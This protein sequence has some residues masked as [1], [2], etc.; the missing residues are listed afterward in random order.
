MLHNLRGFCI[1]LTIIQCT[2]ENLMIDFCVR[3]LMVDHILHNLRYISMSFHF[4]LSHYYMDVTVRI[5]TTTYLYISIVVKYV[6]DN[7]EPD[8]E[9]SNSLEN[10]GLWCDKFR[11]LSD[12][13]AFKKEN[14]GQQIIISL[15]HHFQLS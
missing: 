3:L 1:C 15:S 9:S 13:E 5:W 11:I 8:A 6:V 14:S 12:N 4:W 10:I 2:L 7:K